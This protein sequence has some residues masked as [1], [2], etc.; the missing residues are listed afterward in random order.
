M[1]FTDK[2]GITILPDERGLS[3]Y[4]ICKSVGYSVKNVAVMIKDHATRNVLYL[5]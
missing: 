4:P 2:H 1:T 5:L 3:T